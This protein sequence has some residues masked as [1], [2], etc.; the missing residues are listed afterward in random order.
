MSNLGKNKMPSE[1]ETF[2]SR[3]TK[4]NKPFQTSYGKA[5]GGTIGRLASYQP[6]PPSIAKSLLLEK[7]IVLKELLMK[8]EPELGSGERFKNLTAKLAGQGASNPKALAAYIG[9]KKYGKQHFQE[10]AAAGKKK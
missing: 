5:G 1:S 2:V 4:P 3:G 9:R 10:L 7:A 8:A 6:K